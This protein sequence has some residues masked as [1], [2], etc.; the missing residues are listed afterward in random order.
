[1]LAA[2]GETFTETAAST[3]TVAEPERLVSALDVAVT[4]RLEAGTEAGAVY[5]PLALIVP[6]VAFPPTTPFTLQVTPRFWESL[7]TVA[8]NCWVLEMFSE[9]E[10][11]ETDTLMEDVTAI[12]AAAVLVP[13]AIDVAVSVTVAG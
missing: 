7:F 11:G 13:S 3:V 6:T 8:V 9:A 2:D 1:M 5:S 4:V 12:V 10:A